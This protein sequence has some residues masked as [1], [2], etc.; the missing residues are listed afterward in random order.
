LEC[1]RAGKRDTLCPPDLGAAA[2]TTVAMGVKSYRE[3][4]VFFWDKNERKVVEA[5][6]SWASRLE[7]RSKERGKPKEIA[8]Y[9]GD[10]AGSEL[11]PPDYMKLAGSW[12]NGKDPAAG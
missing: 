9:K 11:Q 1:V 7:K 12:V 5:D 10:P 3:G 2:F 4:K 6:A 8:N